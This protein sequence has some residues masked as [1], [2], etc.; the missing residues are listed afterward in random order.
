VAVILAYVQYTAIEPSIAIPWLCFVALIA[1]YRTVLVK[2][3]LRSKTNDANTHARLAKFRF[4]V[5]LIALAWGSAGVLMFPVSNSQHQMFLIFALAGMSAGGV[6]S[7]SAD[8]VSGIVYATCLI[9]PLLVRLLLVG[10]SLSIGMSVAGALYLSFMMMSLRYVHRSLTDNITLRHDAVTREKA[11]L[12]SEEHY[13]SLLNHAPVGIFH[14]DNNLAITYSNSHFADILQSSADKLVS[15]DLKSIEDQSILP[16]LRKALADE[17]GNYEGPYKAAFG[18]AKGWITLTCAPSK[19]SAGKVTGGIAILQDITDR[20]QAEDEIEKLAFYDTL[21]RLPNRR[22]L[23]ERL[24]HAMD[25]S[26]RNGR[27]GALLYIDLDN[28]KTLNDTLGHQIGDLLLQQVAARITEC[29]RKGD[30]VSRI[31]RLGGDEFVVMLED[32]DEHRLKAAL[33]AELVAEKILASL[34]LPYLLAKHE[35]H[36]TA[37]VGV[38]LFSE[39]LQSVEDLL[40]HADIAM[41]QAKKAGRNML[42]FF[43]P[44][45]QNSINSRADIE[46]ELRKALEKNQFELYYQVQVSALGR[47]LGAEALIRW[48]HPERG[49][50]SPLEFIPLAEETKLILPIG[51]WVLDRACAQLKAWQQESL[52]SYLSISINVSAQQFRQPDFVTQVQRAIELNSINPLRLKLELTE[53]SLLEDIEDTIATM[54]E[55]NAIGIQFSLDDFGTG[56][57]SLQYLKRLP[58]N[59]LKIDSSFVRDLAVNSSDRSIVRTIIAMTDS[60]DLEIIAEGVETEEQRQLLLNKGCMQYQ[61]Y[62]FGRP[63]PIAQFDAALK[64]A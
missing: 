58:I 41:S 59:Q 36:C 46:R 63:M 50:V 24:K 35:H 13:R 6:I 26:E 20:K 4:S 18:A 31:A 8:L 43:D 53:S 56:Y 7:Y 15:S 44:M 55:L 21:T 27:D 64:L 54:S 23:V 2:T 51:Q 10:D 48:L 60:L 19:D 3:Y 17:I 47:P 49:M 42:R 29:L 5:L 37:S 11:V 32:L 52:T 38:A 61:G 28:F 9:L 45:M 25:T 1:V 57:S 40:K 39:H 22:L 14:Y 16:S 34:C 33:Q 30:T 12:A 62:L